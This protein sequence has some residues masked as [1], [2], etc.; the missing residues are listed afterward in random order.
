M[1]GFAPAHEA[2]PRERSGSPGA[3]LIASVPL[4]LKA[5]GPGWQTRANRIL[6]ERFAL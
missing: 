4:F 5:T 2:G 1:S 3:H 6:R